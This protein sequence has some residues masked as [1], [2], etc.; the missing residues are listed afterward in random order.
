MLTT[1]S[2]PKNEHG[3]INS[4]TVKKDCNLNGVM[5][6]AFETAWEIVKALPEQ[7]A[8]GQREPGS[9]FRFAD[10]RDD[11]DM[12]HGFS[13]RGTVHP[14]ILGMM[15]R[16]E[17]ERHDKYVERWEPVEEFT[18]AQNRRIK[19]KPKTVEGILSDGDLR[20]NAE[21]N[22]NSRSRRGGYEPDNALL[23]GP[24][25]PPKFD[26]GW[27]STD[28]HSPN[29]GEFDWTDWDD[30]SMDPH[31]HTHPTRGEVR[32]A[33]FTREGDMDHDVDRSRRRADSELGRRARAMSG[34]TEIDG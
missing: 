22:H 3:G 27:S 8:V 31:W 21:Y 20:L 4:E 29:T 30:D 13:S 15:A 6:E 25:A 28:D 34:K 14:A 12:G 23:Q 7:Q 1:N 24:R 33:A 17:K 9:Q 18:E 11:P 2:T 5:A 32:S 19:P 10:L 26:W 16:R